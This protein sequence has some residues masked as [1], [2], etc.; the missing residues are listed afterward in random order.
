MSLIC[1]SSLK[2][3]FFNAI[4]PS[5]KGGENEPGRHYYAESKGDLKKIKVIQDQR[6]LLNQQ[7]HPFLQKITLR[8]SLS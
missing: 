4:I 5:K 1:F 8:G 7:R 2:V 6:S 3:P